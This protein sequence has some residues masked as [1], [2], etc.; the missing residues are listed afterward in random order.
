MKVAFMKQ[1]LDPTTSTPE[2]FAAFIRDEVAQNIK[3]VKA[4]GI[5][6]E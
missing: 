4:A 2:A 5:K 3:L 6:V 1:G